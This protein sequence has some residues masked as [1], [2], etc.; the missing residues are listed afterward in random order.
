MSSY[1]VQ[2]YD[3]RISFYCI[4]LDLISPKPKLTFRHLKSSVAT[5]L[6]T[7]YIA[8]AVVR[9]YYINTLKQELGSTNAFE[10]NLLGKRYV[11]DRYE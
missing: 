8:V 2:L 1:L 9:M 10:H 4:N 7:V 5:A 11:V 3:K 6:K